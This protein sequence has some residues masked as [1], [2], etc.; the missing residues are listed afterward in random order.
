M[1]NEVWLNREMNLLE[2]LENK[3]FELVINY[4]M[5][6]QQQIISKWLSEDRTSVKESTQV[7]MSMLTRV[8][9]YLKDYYKALFRL[10]ALKGTVE[11]FEHLIYESDLDE[12][13]KRA[14]KDDVLAIKHLDE[15]ILSLEVHGKMTHS[16]I[17]K[18]LDLKESTL[19]EIMKKV[20][21]TKLISHSKVGK[22]KVY[23][24]TESGRRL[25]RQLRSQ[26]QMDVNKKDFL[27]R[28][29]YY[30]EHIAGFDK[31]VKVI[32]ELEEKLMR[33]EE[34]KGYSPIIKSGEKIAISHRNEYGKWECNK[35]EIY[36]ELLD[37]GKGNNERNFFA[38]RYKTNIP[39]IDNRSRIKADKK[40]TKKNVNYI[41]KDVEIE[42]EEVYV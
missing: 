23:M 6:N 8:E 21:M 41:W 3:E 5:D 7:G 35:Y 15:I 37:N 20:N 17:C 9:R 4:A 33:M 11:C 14:Y 27:T 24:L 2:K 10:G 38:T 25:G 22:Y 42:C 29:S 39:G 32:R 18:D 40:N 16:E 31:Q 19:S 1:S 30:F 13:T 36:A 12:W 28:L 26:R 34:E